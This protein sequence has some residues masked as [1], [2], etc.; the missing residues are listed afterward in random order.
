MRSSFLLL[1]FPTIFASPIPSSYYGDWQ[2]WQNWQSTWLTTIAPQI[3]TSSSS[4]PISPY[5]CSNCTQPALITFL[6]EK[7]QP[8]LD[9]LFTNLNT[10]LSNLSLTK[11]HVDSVITSLQQQFS[12]D[13]ISTLENSLYEPSYSLQ[14]RSSETPSLT[15]RHGNSQGSPLSGVYEGFTYQACLTNFASKALTTYE[16]TNFG[17]LTNE[18]CIDFC[19]DKGYTIAGT[20]SGSQCF[21]GNELSSTTLIIEENACATSC[22][23]DSSQVCGDNQKLSVYSSGNIT[24]STFS[25]ERIRSGW[26]EVGCLSEGIG[27]HSLIGAAYSCLGMTVEMCMD[28]CD[29]M[30]FNIAGVEYG[31]ECYC[32]NTFE[33]G[34]GSCTSGCT[35]PCIGNDTQLCGGDWKMNVYQR[36]ESPSLQSCSGSPLTGC[37]LGNCSEYNFTD[38]WSGEGINWN[39]VGVLKPNETDIC[40]QPCEIITYYP[41]FMA[42]IYNNLKTKIADRLKVDWPS[43]IAGLVGDS[44]SCEIEDIANTIAGCGDITYGLDGIAD[45]WLCDLITI[46]KGL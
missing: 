33:N 44:C 39:A 31:G 30:G 25:S 37:T 14:K 16:N 8:Y 22:T 45:S 18:K 38:A 29:V 6:A 11:S 46:I 26:E 5:P 43:R 36:I 42:E 15:K 13:F 4:L 20:Q 35:T 12:G 24:S 10:S 27:N 28:F 32:G 21:C 3:S 2:N 7:W 40:S 23:G 41:F 9:T 17:N 34:G 19:K 1:V